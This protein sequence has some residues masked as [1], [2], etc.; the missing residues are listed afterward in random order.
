LHG[1]HA[2]T[3]TGIDGI[4]RHNNIAHG[5]ALEIERL[6]QQDLFTFVRLL[7]LSGH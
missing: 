6:D 3:N 5:L 4:E 2:I 7:L 1:K